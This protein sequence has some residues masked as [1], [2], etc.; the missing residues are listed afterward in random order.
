M[1][2]TALIEADSLKLLYRI[3][4]V[5]KMK[6]SKIV[7][8]IFRD[9]I[10]KKYPTIRISINSTVKYQL[11][12]GNM[13]LLHYSVPSE[14]YEACLDLRKFGKMSVSRILNE[15]I[16][17]MYNML[18]EADVVKNVKENLISEF[19][20]KLDNY[21]LN[22]SIFRKKTKQRGLITTE[23]HVRIT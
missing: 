18:S 15:G 19:M 4:A 13:I 11:N 22:Y 3:A 1:R 5:R 10:I 16:V 6:I 21:V 14:I 12:C 17:L 7:E 23:I 9:I 8:L 2:T 20:T